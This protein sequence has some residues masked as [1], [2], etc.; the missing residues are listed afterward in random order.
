MPKASSDRQG[1]R[2]LRLL[3][4]CGFLGGMFSLC[5]D[6]FFIPIFLLLHTKRVYRKRSC[7]GFELWRAGS[8]LNVHLMVSV[9]GETGV[10]P[11]V[12]EVLLPCPRR[13]IQ[14]FQYNSFI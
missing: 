2:Q 3:L 14:L 6:N 4:G 7:S 10:W 13:K 12:E 9:F 5:F 8:P 11:P 1:G